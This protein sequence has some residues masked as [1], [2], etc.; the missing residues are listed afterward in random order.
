V[1]LKY[2][3]GCIHCHISPVVKNV[4]KHFKAK[5]DWKENSNVV[6]FPELEKQI[7]L[8]ICFLTTKPYLMRRR[9][10]IHK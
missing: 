6:E 2:C 1:E 5:N 7:Y 8:D 10:R 9:R 4:M 3:L